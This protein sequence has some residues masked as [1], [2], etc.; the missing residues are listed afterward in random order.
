MAWIETISPDGA[1]GELAELYRRIGGARG[2]VADIHQVQS[3]NPKAM[4]AHLEIYK[5][6]VFRR[7]SLSRQDRERIAVVVSHTNRCPYCI[8]HHAAALRNLG[9]PPETVAALSEG[10]LPD[11]LGEQTAALLDWVRRMTLAPA[12]A[13]EADVKHLRE[14]GYDDRA[15]LDATLTCGYFNF[16]NRLVLMLGVHLESDYE[17]TCQADIT[18]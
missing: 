10:R 9:E 4:Q 15:L 13:S 11:S 17:K 12:D 1:E 2:G 16:V 14:L 8:G 5:A 6:V 3:L 18:D 7:S